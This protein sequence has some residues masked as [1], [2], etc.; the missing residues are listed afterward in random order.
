MRCADNVSDTVVDTGLGD[1]LYIAGGQSVRI[2]DLR[3][4]TATA[5]FLTVPRTWRNAGPIRAISLRDDGMLA[6]GVGGGAVAIWDATGPWEG[7]GVG[8]PGRG[9][10]REEARV[11]AMCLT[12]HAALVGCADGYVASLSLHDDTPYDEKLVPASQSKT[13]ICFLAVDDAAA[14]ALVVGRD[15]GSLTVFDPHGAGTAVDWEKAA[16]ACGLHD[17]V[18]A[19]SASPFW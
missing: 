2:I 16:A 1:T 10:H 13:G 6:A 5:A 15:N 3:F 11:R 9:G 14:G 7:R 4:A 17:L 8:W 12:P 19:N 18:G